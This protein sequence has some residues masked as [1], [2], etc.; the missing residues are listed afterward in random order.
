MDGL[1]LFP[2]YKDA[3]SKSIVVAAVKFAILIICT[4]L[5]PTKISKWFYY[6]LIGFVATVTLIVY[7]GC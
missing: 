5:A 1:N 3:Y 6:K 4:F 7:L 2:Y